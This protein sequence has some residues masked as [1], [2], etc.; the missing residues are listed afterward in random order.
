VVLQVTNTGNTAGYINSISATGPAAGVFTLTSLPPLPVRVE[1][2]ATASFGVAFAPI[3]IGQA[4]G[5]LRID[6]QNFNLSGVGDSPPPLPGVSFSGPGSA[7]DAAQQT[8]VGVTLDTPYPVQLS[9]KLTLAFAPSADVFADDPAI[10]FASGG[11]TVNFIVPANSRSAVFGLND[12]QI[13]FQTGTVSGMITM[14]ATFATEAGNI[15]LTTSNP[16]AT[17]IQVRPSAPRII[18]LQLAQ[19]GAASF[20]LVLTGYSPTRSANS[21]DFTFTPFVDPANKDL[22]L[23]TTSSSIAATGPFSVWYQSAASQTFGS[24]F[25]AT[26]TFNVRGNIEALQSVAVTMSNRVGTSSSSVVQ[27]R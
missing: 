6:S 3:S 15:N 20:T 12:S 7:V 11:R 16:P 1:G 4:S 2:G 5:T 14:T 23:E 18:S 25:T 19:R 17:I 13:R 22:K 9:G 10:A 27:L 24:L 8:G 21:L 26:I